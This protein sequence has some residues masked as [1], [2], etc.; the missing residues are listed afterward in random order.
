[1]ATPA[2]HDDS[3]PDNRPLIPD[4][5]ADWQ[6]T[7]SDP[8]T[9]GETRDSPPLTAIVQAIVDRSD[10]SSG[11]A[12]AIITQ[13]V[14]TATGTWRH[15]R[16]IGYERPVWYPGTEY[17]A[18]LVVTYGEQPPPPSPAPDWSAFG[19]Q[20]GADYGLPVA[21]AGDVNGD[22]YGDVIVGA[23][24]YDAGE[25]DEGRAFVYYGTS[26]GL[27]PTPN[28]IAE[29]N[30]A[31][32]LFGYP[33]STAGDV[34][35]DGYADVIVGAQNYDAAGTTDAGRAYVYFGSA[36]GLSTTPNWTATGDQTGDQFGVAVD[37]AGDINGD[38]YADIIVGANTYDNGETDEGRAYVY[39][40]SPSGPRVTPDWMAEVDHAGAYFGSYLGTAGDVNG[41]GYADVIIGAWGYDHVFGYFGSASGLSNTPNWTAVGDQSGS[42]FGTVST[43]GDVNG[44]GYADVIVGADRYTG[45][46][47]QEGR[48]FVY[49][50]SASGPSTTPNWTVS[51][52][53]WGAWLGHGVSTAGDV[54]G[55]GYGDVI[56]GAQAYDND[57]TNEGRAW[58]YYGSASGLETTPAWTAE[59]NRENSAFGYEVSTAG[60]VDGDGYAD[61]IVGDYYYTNVEAHEGA[62]FVY[63]GG[64]DG[65]STTADWMT[66]G[67][68]QYRARYGIIAS[69]GDVNGDGYA[70]VVVGEPEYDGG[71]SDEG[72]AVCLLWLGRWPESYRTLD[73]G[74]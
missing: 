17:A 60:D 44:D 24:H 8:W 39:Y 38:G 21:S 22:G 64:P 30:Q 1:M 74:G 28:W 41:D 72:R 27:S 67:S 18:R 15:R 32:A 68:H 71:E 2:L 31:G 19:G 58:I 73:R 37:T 26:T 56:V 25:V 52:G 34:N 45:A 35:G 42:R 12:L 36:S 16:V 51:G 6:I 48:A 69:T 10:W 7:P 33:V 70:D 20:E 54:N 55:D 40:G 11:N 9:L 65:L 4:V 43:A 62:A 53:Q 59:S 49:Y 3:R 29:S 66:E 46:N 14:G 61:V 50:G 57:Q 13:N 47:F 63:H 5:M 23:P